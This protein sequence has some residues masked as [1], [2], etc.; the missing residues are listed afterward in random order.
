MEEAVRSAKEEERKRILALGEI[1]NGSA[2][3]DAIVDAAVA[4][5]RSAETVAID[6]IRAMKSAKEESREA[7]FA[8]LDSLV[9]DTHEAEVERRAE[10]ENPYIAAAKE[11]GKEKK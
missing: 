6:I 4:D 1:R 5:G 7:R 3:V 10:E 2:E 9:D 8:E 11:M